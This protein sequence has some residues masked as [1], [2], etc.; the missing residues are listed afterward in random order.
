MV[1]LG[2]FTYLV[3]Q[4]LGATIFDHENGIL[5][6]Y[7]WSLPDGYLRKGTLS[8][9]GDSVSNSLGRSVLSRALWKTLYEGCIRWY[10]WIYPFIYGHQNDDDDLDFRPE[11]VIE[12]IQKVLNSS[13][14]QREGSLMVLKNGIHFAISLN[15]TT[16]QKLIKKPDTQTQNSR[17]QSKLRC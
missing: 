13:E 11:V 4:T 1:T 6:S 9:Y 17:E 3:H 14:M 15:F 16:Y 8:V 5:E 7:D 10:Q 12:N 2:E